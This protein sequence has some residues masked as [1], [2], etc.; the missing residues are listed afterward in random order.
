MDNIRLKNKIQKMQQILFV[1]NK[2]INNLKLNFSSQMQL[3]NQKLIKLYFNISEEINK[4]Y[5]EDECDDNEKDDIGMNEL[6]EKDLIGENNDEKTNEYKTAFEI[7]TKLLK[8][9]V[10]NSNDPKFR[11][12]K[13]TNVIISSKLLNISEMVEVLEILGYEVGTGEKENC[14]VYEGNRFES[15]K[16]CLEVLNNLFLPFF[17]INLNLNLNDSFS[18]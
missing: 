18:Y 3:M 9:I 15:L 8:N 13:K 12:I 1:K 11:I 14:Y 10:D 4:L 5:L 7:L 16:D 2:E 17:D 6:S